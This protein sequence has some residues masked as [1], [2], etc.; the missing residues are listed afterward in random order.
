MVGAE[1]CGLCWKLAPLLLLLRLVVGRLALLVM[2]W[3]TRTVD[4]MILAWNLHLGFVWIP[5]R[6]HRRGSQWLGLNCP[7][8]ALRMMC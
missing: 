1:S 3:M 5:L 2:I 7:D 6:F 4:L 8:S